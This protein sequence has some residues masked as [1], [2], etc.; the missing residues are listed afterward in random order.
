M[1]IFTLFFMMSKTFKVF[2]FTDIMFNNKSVLPLAFLYQYLSALGYVI[3]DSEK[4]TSDE[5][6]YVRLC[7]VLPSLYTD[8]VK[9]DK[10]ETNEVKNKD[11]YISQIK[12][13]LIDYK[14]SDELSS[15]LVN[16]TL[17]FL[18]ALCT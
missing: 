6:L 7:T 18:G 4:S 8:L 17:N 11:K 10:G 3:E 13:I 16:K 14:P 15:M 9:V 1:Q 2:L 12:N 5:L